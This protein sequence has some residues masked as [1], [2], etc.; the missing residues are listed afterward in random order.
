MK[1]SHSVEE[2]LIHQGTSEDCLKDLIPFK[3][4]LD[5]MESTAS[6]KT[7]YDRLSEWSD[8]AYGYVH[9]MLKKRGFVSGD[10]EANANKPDAGFW[11]KVYGIVSSVCYSSNLKQTAL[12]ATHHTSAYDRNEALRKDIDVIIRKFI[13]FEPIGKYSY[14]VFYV[15]ADY[16]I[17][18]ST[19]GDNKKHAIENFKKEYGPD[20]KV[21]HLQRLSY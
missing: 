3:E 7:H 8:K 4:L 5:S 11:W 10:M 1:Y 16:E 21:K 9:D 20:V 19:R 2:C 15:D 13:K 12:V 18:G 6:K 17:T 14:D